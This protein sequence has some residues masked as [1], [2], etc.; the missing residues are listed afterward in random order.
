MTRFMKRQRPVLLLLTLVAVLVSAPIIRGNVAGGIGPNGQKARPFYNVAHNPNTVAEAIEALD[1]GANALGPDVMRFA[2][3]A[4]FNGTLV[5]STAG[6]SGLFMYHDNVLLPT[7]MP[8][9]LESY[10]DALHT[11]AKQG[12][13]LAL[14]EF[15][16]KSP[17]AEYL[18]VH[19]FKKLSDAV[20]THLNHDGVNV[21][22]IYSVATTSDSN[23]FMNDICLGPREGIMIDQEN[24]A[25]AV[26]NA[27]LA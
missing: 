24:D 18:G 14:I 19:G 2:G 7:R 17:T 1:H 22:I 12:K 8:T 4:I 11:A 25:A 9:T 10:L 6:D 27:L 23:Y 5:N 16:I 15:D 26:L 21:N 13:N 3:G 20:A